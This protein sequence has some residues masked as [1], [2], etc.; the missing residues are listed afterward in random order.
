MY[1]LWKEISWQKYWSSLQKEQ[2]ML[3][4]EMCRKKK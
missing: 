1:L 3:P 2:E 4:D